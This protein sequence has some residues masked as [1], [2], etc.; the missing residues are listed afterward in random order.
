MLDYQTECGVAI[1][2]PEDPDRAR[3]VVQ[4]SSVPALLLCGPGE[5]ATGASGQGASAKT[6]PPL[7]FQDHCKDGFAYFCVL[8]SGYATRGDLRKFVES[9]IKVFFGVK[10]V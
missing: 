5:A 4:G 3:C 7:G 1:L 6:S 8:L 2:V 10:D 9:G